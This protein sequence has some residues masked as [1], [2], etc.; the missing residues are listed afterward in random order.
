MSNLFLSLL[1]SISLLGLNREDIHQ[2]LTDIK[3]S[4]VGHTSVSQTFTSHYSNLDIVSICIRNPRR[5]LLPLKFEL[6][7]DD[8]EVP[9]RTIDFSGGNISEDD[10]TRF[11]FDPITDSQNKVYK[12]MIT[13]VSPEKDDP[14]TG[15]YIE[16]FKGEDYVDGTAYLDNVDLGYDLHFKTA[17]RQDIRTI[18]K[19]SFTQF[20]TRLFKDIAFLIFYLLLISFTFNKLRRTK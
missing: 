16:S 3:P 20:G 18:F 19:E 1:T 17:Y 12:A 11:Q 9:V 10:C 4:F 15:M 2:P 6:Y 8:I 13:A 14:H 7:Q 5:L